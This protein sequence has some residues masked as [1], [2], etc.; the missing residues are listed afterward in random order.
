MHRNIG[1]LGLSPYHRPSAQTMAGTA[2]TARSRGGDNLTYLRIIGVVPPGDVLVIDAGADL[3]N[4]VIGG[5][6]DLLCR[7]DRLGRNRARR[8][9]AQH[10]RDSRAGL[11]RLRARRDASRTLQGR[12]RRDQ[13]SRV[14]RGNGCQSGRHHS[15]RPGWRAGH[16]AG[17]A[18]LVIQKARD[19][20]AA[21]A[22]TM[23]AIRA[24]KWDRWFSMFSRPV[25]TGTRPEF[26]VATRVA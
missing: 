16:S 21:E 19:V 9:D 25:A 23:E 17:N 10:R 22:R 15:W 2:V 11:S 20:L 13:C 6:I 3:N 24:G 18:E 26:A 14:G 7:D 5:I 1:T 8:S 4:A 12:T